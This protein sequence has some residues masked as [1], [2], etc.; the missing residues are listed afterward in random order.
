MHRSHPHP[1]LLAA[2]AALVAL[3]GCAVAN[4]AMRSDFSDFN[5]ILQT[6]VTQQMVLNL[7]R[8]RHREVPMLLRAGTLTASYESSIHA[9]PYAAA[10]ID[11]NGGLSLGLDYGFASKP[12]VT[13]T[14]VE[15]KDYV[16]QFMTEVSPE[17]FAMLVRAGWPIT[18][19]GNVLI[20]R[21]TLPSGEVLIGRPEAPSYPKFQRFLKDLQD[22]EDAFT[23]NIVA[24]AAGKGVVLTAGG[25]SY[26]LESFQFRSLFSAMFHAAKGVRTPAEQSGEVGSA[27]AFDELTIEVSDK[28]PAN[29]LVLVQHDGHFYSVARSDRR[30]KDTLALLLELGRIQAGPTG[31]AP[32]VTIPAR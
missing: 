6:S 25:Q 12:T 31:P 17:T 3:P 27:G 29:A 23:L 1:I 11:G 8:L 21:V 26:P 4:N 2:V 22:A 32:L 13:Y 10:S 19:L 28:P 14:P 15:G 24:G 20:E 18:K 16:A 30:S 5:Q 7:V 9:S